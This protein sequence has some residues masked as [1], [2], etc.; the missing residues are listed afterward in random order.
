MVTMSEVQIRRAVVADADA[1]S[2]TVTR[3]LRETNAADYAP[4]IIEAA[5]ANFS[6]EKVRSRFA[7]R[8]TLV[9][10]QSGRVVGT[11]SL[12]KRTA[13]TVFVDPE[14]QARG[15]GTALMQAVEQAAVAQGTEVLTVPS[16]VTAEG[17]YRNL[18]FVALRV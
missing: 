13:R 1:I 18:G 3:A 11:A 7:D 14:H 2:R 6:S 9:A 15:I 10:T 16:S 5:A 12:Q 8:I 17:F 4:E